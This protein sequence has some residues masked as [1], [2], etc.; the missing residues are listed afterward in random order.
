MVEPDASI[1]GTQVVVVPEAVL[2][3]ANAPP[4]GRLRKSQKS[5]K[6]STDPKTEPPS[7][8]KCRSL[9]TS[10]CSRRPSP[11]YSSDAKAAVAIWL[12]AVQVNVNPL[13]GS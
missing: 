8:R 2:E 11:S 4:P 10:D 7:C 3:P 9:A 1:S 5:P 13:A 12:R 6:L